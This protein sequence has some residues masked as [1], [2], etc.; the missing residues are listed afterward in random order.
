MASDLIPVAVP[1]IIEALLSVVLPG[2]KLL[3]QRI[4]HGDLGEM[5]PHV[6][7]QLHAPPLI[8]LHR[9]G[10]RH[11]LAV[12]LFLHRRDKENELRSHGIQILCQVMEILPH[13][14][15]ILL[16]KEVGPLV[17]FQRLSVIAAE[18]QPGMVFGENDRIAAD[19]RIFQVLRPFRGSFFCRLL[20]RL[21]LFCHFLLRLSLRCLCFS[22]PSGSCCRAA[23]RKSCHEQSCCRKCI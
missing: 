2:R 17:G 15:Q 8:V 13:S 10:R 12:D 4:D 3:L 21:L 19:I 20:R 5:F 14:C 18:E 6:V 22:C 11:P 7:Y 23:G 16:R 1:F 9:D